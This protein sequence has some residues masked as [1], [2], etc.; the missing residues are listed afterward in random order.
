MEH[1]NAEIETIRGLE[2]FGEE[3][4]AEI[5]DINAHGQAVGEVVVKTCNIPITGQHCIP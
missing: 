5:L 3:R 4:M 1:L 2:E